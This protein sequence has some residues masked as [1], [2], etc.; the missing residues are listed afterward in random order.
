MVR[1]QNTRRKR[2]T[3]VIQVPRNELHDST[4]GIRGEAVLGYMQPGLTWHA[5]LALAD[6]TQGRPV[7]APTA[8]LPYCNANQVLRK[9]P[10]NSLQ[11]RLRVLQK[12]QRHARLHHTCTWHPHHPHNIQSIRTQIKI[13]H[14]PCDHKERLTQASLDL[15]ALSHRRGKNTETRNENVS[16]CRLTPAVAAQS[17]SCAQAEEVARPSVL[18]G[19]A[20]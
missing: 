19:L 13:P 15:Q 6:S 18:R 17:P 11:L 7:P 2:K 8:E 10:L 16:T 20:L 9:G 14:S 1:Y 4:R 12:M 3:M 5:G